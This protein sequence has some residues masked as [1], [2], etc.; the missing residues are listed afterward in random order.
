[1]DIKMESNKTEAKN[2]NNTF[3]VIEKSSG[4]DSLIFSFS[5]TCQR[6]A[7]HCREQFQAVARLSSDSLTEV[8]VKHMN[9]FILIHA[10]QIAMFN[11]SVV[12]QKKSIFLFED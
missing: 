6:A 12:D 11:C 9:G 10:L 2:R 7:E 8:P 5:L 1:M 3:L 4:L